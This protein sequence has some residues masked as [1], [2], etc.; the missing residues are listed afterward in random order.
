MNEIVNRF[1]LFILDFSKKISALL[2]EGG[3]SFGSAGVSKG[4]ILS[5]SIGHGNT[6][7]I[8]IASIIFSS[9]I[10]GM[11]LGRSRL[12]M[13]IVSIY[14]ASSLSDKFP[15]YTQIA[16]YFKETEGYLI[17]ISIFLFFY[18][19][20]FLF[21]NKSMIRS[22]FTLNE[23]PFFAI[24]FLS[25]IHGAFLLTNL[26]FFFPEPLINKFSPIL[27]S[28]FTTQKAQFVWALLP[29]LSFVFLGRK[30]TQVDN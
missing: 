2:M 23:V 13:G 19:L 4:S 1:L 10:I 16:A 15:F 25:I 9:F 17:K 5:N 11:A 30:K 8:L 3:F 26:L 12:M 28:Y 20:T 6:D 24:L 14:I 18:L 29:V 7:L 27:I 22:R 21:L